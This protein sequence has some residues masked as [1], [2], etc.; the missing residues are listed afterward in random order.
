M[1]INDLKI[2]LRAIPV[3]EKAWT[4]EYRLS[5]DQDLSY[6]VEHNWLWGLI[7]FKTKHKYLVMWEEVTYVYYHGHSY[8]YDINSNNHIKL[9]V[10]CKTKEEFEAYKEKCKTFGDLKKCIAEIE[11]KSLED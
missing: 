5:P 9:P 4:L 1:N 6:E 11:R 8:M 3:T 10:S 2:E 7:K